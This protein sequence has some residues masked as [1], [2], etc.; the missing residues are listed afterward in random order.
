MLGLQTNYDMQTAMRLQA[1]ARSS[2]ASASTSSRQL[3]SASN[4]RNWKFSKNLYQAGFD[5][6]VGQTNSLEKHT[7]KKKVESPA[8]KER[9]RRTNMLTKMAQEHFIHKQDEHALEDARK[10]EEVQ[11]KLEELKRRKEARIKRDRSRR[12]RK[13]E[14]TAARKI[15]Y[16][17]RFIILSRMERA[18]SMLRIFVRKVANRNAVSVASWAAGVIRRFAVYASFRW[19]FRK[20]I[21]QIS[22][23]MAHNMWHDSVGMKAIAEVSGVKIAARFVSMHSLRQGLVSVAKARIA[24]LRE[25]ERSRRKAQRWGKARGMKKIAGLSKAPKSPS[26]GS[27]SPQSSPSAKLSGGTAA[28]SVIETQVSAG[29]CVSPPAT[30]DTTEQ[31]IFEAKKNIVGAAHVPAAESAL[32][33]SFDFGLAMNFDLDNALD[34][35]QYDEDIELERERKE[36]MREEHRRRQEAQER[37]R[38]ARL[39]AIAKAKVI[40]EAE[41][42]EQR[43]LDR[44]I[45]EARERARL[46]WLAMQDEKR[47][48][49]SKKLT[50]SRKLKAKEEKKEAGEQERMTAEDTL[51]PKALKDKWIP[52]TIP[53]Q[54][55]KKPREPTEFEI[56]MA[57]ER[58]EEEEKQKQEAIE[59]LFQTNK[60]NT[61]ARL[62]KMAEKK[63]KEMLRKEEEEEKKRHKMEQL[64]EN[65]SRAL[66]KA[67]EAKRIADMHAKQR[68]KEL[69]AID[70]VD[71]VGKGRTHNASGKPIL[72]GF[73]S[74]DERKSTKKKSAL[75]GLNISSKMPVQDPTG[76][77]RQWNY[78]I[79]PSDGEKPIE[80]DT[81]DEYRE[82]LAVAE[83]HPLEE[84]ELE[85]GDDDYWPFGEESNDEADFDAEEGSIGGLRWGE[86]RVVGEDGDEVQLGETN[87]PPSAELQPG[88]ARKPKKKKSGKVSLNDKTKSVVEIAGSHKRDV[89]IPS[90]FKDSAYFKSY[91]YVKQAEEAAEKAAKELEKADADVTGGGATS[92]PEDKDVSADNKE[93]KK[94]RA[95]RQGK[96]ATMLEMVNKAR[97]KMKQQAKS[98]ATLPIKP[99]LDAKAMQV[100]QQA[101]FTSQSTAHLESGASPDS[102]SG[103]L[104][105]QTAPPVPRMP[106]PPKL[107]DFAV[108]SE[109]KHG[110]EEE[111]EIG[112]NLEEISTMHNEELEKLD[113]AEDTELLSGSLTDY[114]F[115]KKESSE[116]GQ[117]GFVTADYSRSR[118]TGPEYHSPIEVGH[119]EEE[120]YEDTVEVSV[121]AR[122][123]QRQED[124]LNA[125]CDALLLRLEARLGVS[126]SQSTDKRGDAVTVKHV[127]VPSVSPGVPPPAVKAPPPRKKTPKAPKDGPSYAKA[128][129]TVTAAYLNRVRQEA[130]MEYQQEG[131]SGDYSIGVDLPSFE[132]PKSASGAQYSKRLLEEWM[133]ED[134]QNS[135]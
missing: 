48:R 28:V 87:K 21:K 11:N 1:A 45:E 100:T 2:S 132:L 76:Q 94:K 22:S 17:F 10:L 135:D 3:E 16:F 50:R 111:E 122:E 59:K 108:T 93:K 20:A 73:V 5:N 18:A 19:R 51:V 97:L 26:S 121:E 115:A 41:E 113:T 109:E 96:V 119:A 71:K 54:R 64:E 66:A 29:K 46:D 104:A 72:K 42:K 114:H 95:A 44:E 82:F 58:A 110:V 24:K 133:A 15:Q 69:A 83:P 88:G 43:E 86:S 120:R 123:E 129:M 9:K 32:A 39:R 107:K 31:A 60:E 90:K 118:E 68:Q 105:S 131:Y 23:S 75:K 56:Q 91:K 80:T 61:E 103:K 52:G 4:N 35:D 98:T 37:E 53:R 40:R 13:V 99:A 36:A 77:V 101:M 126:S 106:T 62:K 124:A 74:A 112:G 6:V 12:K 78:D 92:V 7:K 57:E 65:R 47:E 102:F 85:M 89:K 27:P 134:A 128:S 34:D 33:S 79:E 55:K 130:E 127:N 125:E 38:E 14:Y 70:A 49:I 8:E 63:E 117:K 25:A 116:E 30:M 84:V 81:I 67:V